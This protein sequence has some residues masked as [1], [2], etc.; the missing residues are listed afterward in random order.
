MDQ[1]SK[2]IAINTDPNAPMFQIAHYRIVGEVGEV[3]PMIIKALRE[4][5]TDQR[6][7]E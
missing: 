5:S 4:R 3:V 1:S 7:A 6:E 2:I